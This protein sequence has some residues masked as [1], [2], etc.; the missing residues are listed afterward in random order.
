MVSERYRRNLWDSQ[1]GSR[2]SEIDSRLRS[3]EGLQNT[4]F[5]TGRHCVSLKPRPLFI[6]PCDSVQQVLERLEV[7]PPGCRL[8]RRFYQVIARDKYW[9]HTPHRRCA[10]L[11]ILRL[12]FEKFPP[13]DSPAVIRS[14]VGE[15]G[16]H[17]RIA[18][19]R[20]CGI[21]KPSKGQ[22]KVSMIGGHALQQVFRQSLVPLVCRED[23]KLSAQSC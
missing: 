6:W 7:L 15:Q 14:G 4:L 12:C 2:Q 1:T 21:A 11:S 23:A 9:V 13:L 5:G 20:G 22:R 17:F 19:R 3:A 10:R 16:S 18:S 8:E